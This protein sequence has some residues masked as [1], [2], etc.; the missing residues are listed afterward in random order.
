[1]KTL[2]P[3]TLFVTLLYSCTLADPQFVRVLSVPPG[4]LVIADAQHIGP[5]PI[6][7]MLD[8]TKDHKIDVLMSGYEPYSIVIKSHRKSTW[9]RFTGELIL[10][11]ATAGIYFLL[12]GHGPIYE[13]YYLE[14]RRVEAYLRYKGS[15]PTARPGT[16]AVIEIPEGVS[17]TRIKVVLLKHKPNKEWY[18]LGKLRKSS[19]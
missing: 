7:T 11:I 16:S 13:K 17:I 1:M 2:V 9:L 18:F 14:P 12:V 8:P 19:I 10:G 4:A 5:A 15:K 6:T 3:L